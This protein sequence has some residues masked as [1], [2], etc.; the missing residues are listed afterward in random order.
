MLLKE[1]KLENIRSYENETISF[2]AGSTLLS[3]DIGSGKSSI[4]YAIEFALFGA[5]RTSLSGDALLRKGAVSAS[6]ELTF[7]LNG[8][9]IVVKRSLKKTSTGIKQAA[10]HILIG[11]AKKELTAV[12]LKA[13][14]IGLLGY[15]EE[16]ATKDKNYLFRYTVYCPQE[17]MKLILQENSDNRL[18]ILRKI[19]N[20]DKYRIIRDN[21]SG[22]LKEM[23]KDLAVKE[24]KLE[25]IVALQEKIEIL[26]K[27]ITTIN[28]KLIEFDAKKKESSEKLMFVREKILKL[29]QKEKEVKLLREEVLQKETMLKGLEESLVVLAEKEKKITEVLSS[30]LLVESLNK[31]KVVVEI[32]SLR[33]EKK[34]FA[35][36]KLLIGGKIKNFQEK[37]AYLQKEIALLVLPKDIIQKEK[38][39]LLLKESVLT[40]ES[41]VKKK[42]EKEEDEKKLLALLSKEKALLEEKEKVIDKILSLED[43]PMCLQNVGHEH[44][45]GI[46]A[47]ESENKR[48]LA[49]KIKTFEDELV[50]LLEEKKRIVLDLEKTVE[51]E[52][53]L[54]SLELELKS[55]AEKKLR[56]DKLR[57]EILELAKGNNIAMKKLTEMQEQEGVQLERIEKRLVQLERLKEKL[58]LKEG[59]EKQL[60]EIVCEKEKNLSERENLSSKLVILREKLLDDSGEKVDVGVLRVE[61]ER[62][63]KLDNEFSL[64]LEKEKT[65]FRYINKEKVGLVKDLDVLLVLKNQFIKNKENY[66]WLHDFF[67]PLTHTIE[68]ELLFRIYHHFNELFQ[69]WFGLLV[70]DNQISARLDEAFTPIIEQN[71]HEI[72]FNHLS[73]GE[74]TA[75]S[76]AYRLSLNKVINDVIHHIN[77]KDLLILDEPTD[78]FSSEQL[79]KMHD[80]FDKLSLKQV[81]LVSHEAKVESFVDQ[82]IRVEKEEHCSKVIL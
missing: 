9:E 2:P 36:Q 12:E 45:E 67:L 62:L 35:E 43:C 26:Q 4:L 22:Y 81:V 66:I 70:E 72:V 7:E 10:G 14:L 41:F 59:Q 79:E 82:V 47:K 15:P 56:K 51:D 33:F 74:R 46:L 18:N 32:E 53:K 19:F 71:G 13:E 76:L 42:L 52:K 64:V 78:G 80:L 34:K 69:E 48:V 21:L 3:G 77:T 28:A 11:G 27:E 30:F 60:K 24:A 63:T 5:S 58:L 6:V 23:R 17:E 8:A 65:S 1:L 40:K 44:K 39:L 75:V 20:I 73:G 16:L 55:V 25:P 37:I 29:E 68:K 54:L 49:D 38:R 31:E 57:R 50:V 61:Y